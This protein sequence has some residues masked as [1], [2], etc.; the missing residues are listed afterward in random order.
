MAEQHLT[1]FKFWNKLIVS[2][3]SSVFFIFLSPWLRPLFTLS[4]KANFSHLVFLFLHPHTAGH[5]LLWFFFASFTNSL[6]PCSWSSSDF[7]SS[8]MWVSDW[9]LCLCDWLQPLSH[10]NVGWPSLRMLWILHTSKIANCLTITVMF[11]KAFKVRLA[12]V[13]TF[14]LISA[15]V[16]PLQSSFRIFVFL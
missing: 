2:L 10:S 12:I 13:A 11:G 15:K 8:K 6:F 3:M 4:F 14:Y 1:L 5:T 16:N 7:S 9:H